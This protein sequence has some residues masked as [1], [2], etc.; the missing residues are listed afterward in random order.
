[1]VIKSLEEKKYLFCKRCNK[2]FPIGENILISSSFKDKNNEIKIID[3]N[4]ESQFPT[5]NVLCPQCNELVEAQWW[6]QQTRSA[7]EPPTRFYQ[8]KKCKY[9]WRDYS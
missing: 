6:M 9:R 5:T 3:E 8:C 2:N 1:L 4:E 7:D